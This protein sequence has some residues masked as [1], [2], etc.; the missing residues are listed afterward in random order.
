[1][2]LL[3]HGE[4]GLERATLAT[5]VLYKNSISAISHLRAEEIKD[6]F[7]GAD[8]VELLPQAGQTLF[9]LAMKARC[10]QTESNNPLFY[11]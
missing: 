1:M 7:E 9:D 5:E 6:I 3:V 10:F 2:T 11:F 4:E 8:V